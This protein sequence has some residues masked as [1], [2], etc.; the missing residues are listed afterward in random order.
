[1]P[2]WKTYLN[3]GTIIGLVLYAFF[4]LILYVFDISPLGNIKWLSILVQYGLLFYFLKKIRSQYFQNEFTI[5]QAF[6]SSMYVVLVY[7]TLFSALIFLH[8]SFLDTSFVDKYIEDL[9]LS[10]DEM[11]RT[12]VFSSMIDSMEEVITSVS[13]KEIAW[14][15]LVNK[16]FGGLFVSFAFSFVLRKNANS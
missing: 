9:K 7:A 1:M 5:R 12:G 11:K 2:T 4:L 14:G 16:F 3:A 15:D 10:V 8:G 13:L 6:S